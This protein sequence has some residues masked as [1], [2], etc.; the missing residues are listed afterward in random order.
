M[1]RPGSLVAA[2]LVMACGPAASDAT[3]PAAG[4]GDRDG[5]SLHAFERVE[6]EVL[7]DLAA[8]DR[9]I[10]MRA[11]LT[12]S[13]DDLRRV[14]MAAVLREDPTVA[15]IDGAIDPFSFDARARGLEATKQKLD[16]S[17][18]SPTGSFASERELLRRL[19]AS[20][21]VRLEEERRLPRSASALI[22]A[23]VDTWRPPRSE[24][25]LAEYDRWLSQRLEA[26][27]EAMTSGAPENQLDV[28]R[29]RELDDA[30]DALEHLAATPGFT[31]T[32][33]E[34]VRMRD[35]L[36]TAGSRPAAKA[37]SEWDAT[38]RRA[39][40]HLGFIASAENLARDLAALEVDLRARA[41][42]AVTKARVDRDVLGV[43]LDKQL[44]PADACVEAVPGSRVRSMAASPEREPGC[45]LRRL[46]ARAAVPCE[47]DDDTCRAQNASVARALAAMHDH[48]VVAQWALDVARGA[49][50]IVEAE[51]KHHLLI[52][53]LADARARYER[54][55]LA[56]P[57]AAIG[58]GEAVRILMAGDPKTRAKAWSALGELP[59]D[60][61]ERE[62][63]SSSSRGGDGDAR[64]SPTSR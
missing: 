23:I 14:T 42:R 50:T 10:A 57:I 28:V 41:E 25:E 59:L 47:T 9:R 45:H 5:R 1:W 15:V 12:P 32:T 61:V 39:R 17:D 54:I 35:A 48:V 27:R 33:Q 36:E 51:G 18:V 8:I 52:P 37:R 2:A 44:F 16:A 13:E 19:V 24:R 11:R 7:H 20:E 46:V 43:G 3:R 4:P 40:A 29:A 62:L 38:A 22:R 21:I 60:V 26:V 64:V 56:R 53:V 34:L 58:A 63:P 55:A 6:D 49:S 30:L 31:K